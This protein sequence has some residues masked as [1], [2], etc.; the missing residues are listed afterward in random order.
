MHFAVGVLRKF[1]FHRRQRRKSTAIPTSVNF[2]KR[3]PSGRQRVPRARHMTAGHGVR[4][5][6]RNRSN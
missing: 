5:R 1:F 2:D 3:S 6:L 4:L